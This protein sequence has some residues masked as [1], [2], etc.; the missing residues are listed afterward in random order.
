M[1][2][3]EKNICLSECATRLSVSTAPHLVPH[4]L[5]LIQMCAC[6]RIFSGIEC[7]S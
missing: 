2:I 4:M 5:Y 3:L 1:R 6:L 7:F